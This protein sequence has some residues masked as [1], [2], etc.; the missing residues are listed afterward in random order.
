MFKNS[1]KTRTIYEYLMEV[2]K[3]FLIEKKEMFVDWSNIVLFM[4][5]GVDI[6]AFDSWDLELSRR[7]LFGL[8]LA[9]L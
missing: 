4:D 8:R 2:H 6:K 9:S 5:K 7:F 3:S 1:C